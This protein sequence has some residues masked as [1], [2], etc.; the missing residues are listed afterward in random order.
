MSVPN[1][2][3]DRS[4]G[5]ESTG[6]AANKRSARPGIR[7]RLFSVG[8]GRILVILLV[9]VI[10]QLASGTVVPDYLVSSP[11]HVLDRIIDLIK[12]G[13]VYGDFRVTAVEF[14]LG[15]LLGVGCGLV[16]GLTLGAW[17]TV[18]KIFEPL[19]SALN[20]IPKIA[21]GPI[22]ILW[23]GIGI[24]S[25]VGIAVMTVFFVMFYNVYV[26]IRGVPKNL[27]NT[28]KVIGANR[29]TIIRVV[30]LPQLTMAILSGLRSGI[31]FAVIGVIV[32]EFLASTEGLGHYIRT[33]TDSYDAAGI[34]AGI[35]FLMVLV[36]LMNFLVTLWERRVTRWQR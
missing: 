3:A 5:T 19:I 21:L 4:V 31:P 17:P 6:T 14:V 20:G 34:F 22:F 15:Y 11:V 12:S 2:A 16:F 32:G 26:G 7:R 24:S 28:M 13:Q 23:L 29:L 27:V 18:G 1:V 9:L 8:I 30:V 35:V 36:F 25:K 10:W 33:S